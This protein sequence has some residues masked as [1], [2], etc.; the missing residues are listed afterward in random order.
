MGA[1]YYRMYPEYKFAV[2]KLNSKILSVQELEQLNYEYKSDTNYS[3]IHYLL[4]D[5]NKD[6]KLSFSIRD[7]KRLSD[8]YNTEFQANN[9]KIIVWLVSQPMVTALTHLF[10]L[11][12][13][14]N[15]KYCSTIEKAY[16]LLNIPLE[17]DKFK[18]L[19]K[20]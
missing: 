14:D 8:S 11:Q 2:V 10:V 16:K 13:N 17:F 18:E 4:I 1:N 3:N 20:I 9:H 7:L 19:I 6:S 12:I 15:S 5:I